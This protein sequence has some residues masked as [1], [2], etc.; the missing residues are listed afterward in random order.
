[1]SS[2]SLFRCNRPFRNRQFFTVL[3]PDTFCVTQVFR[4][5]FPADFSQLFVNNCTGFR[6]G[7]FCLCNCL[8]RCILTL[9][10]G[11]G[12]LRR[13]SKRLLADFAF[14][15]YFRFKFLKPFV[16]LRYQ[17]IFF[18]NGCF[19]MYKLDFLF[20]NFLFLISNQRHYIDFLLRQFWFDKRLRCK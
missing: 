20:F 7:Q 19:C 9:L 17:G 16:T 18:R 2:C 15:F 11:T 8:S 5:R 4:I 10:F 13:K 1:M 14:F 3:R 12:A 6:F